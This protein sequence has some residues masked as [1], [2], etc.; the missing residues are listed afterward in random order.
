MLSL[1]LGQAPYLISSYLILSNIHELLVGLK[2]G[3][4]TYGDIVPLVLRKASFY[5]AQLNK[6]C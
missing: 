1:L 2:Q 3:R 5:T 4:D 6:A